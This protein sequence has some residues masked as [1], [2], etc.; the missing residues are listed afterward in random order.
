VGDINEIGCQNSDGMAQ[1]QSAD[2]RYLKP[3]API[4]RAD[5]AKELFLDRRNEF[6]DI[7]RQLP[8]S[9]LIVHDFLLLESRNSPGFGFPS[10]SRCGMCAAGLRSIWRRNRSIVLKPL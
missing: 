5:L 6:T 7:F 4:F 3:T 1:Q 9:A 8:L 10:L 2:R